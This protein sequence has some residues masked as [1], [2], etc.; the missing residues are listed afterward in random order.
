LPPLHL[1]YCPRQTGPDLGKVFYSSDGAAMAVV[2]TP[3]LF[4]KLK[5]D[6][7]MVTVKA[8]QVVTSSGEEAHFD[9]WDG[10]YL[11]TTRIA[12][13]R[14][15]EEAGIA[16]PR[17]EL[18]LMDVHDCFSIT[19]MVTMEDLH[20]SPP[21]GAVDDVLDGFFDLDGGVPC[22]TDGG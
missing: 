8:L 10:S 7:D 17:E 18:S 12:V 13:T 3:E 1:F 4:K 9:A 22:Q 6:Q 5:G 2:T 14:A 21:G 16:D 15:Y 19:E 11:Q 20:I